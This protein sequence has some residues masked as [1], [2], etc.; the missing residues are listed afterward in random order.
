MPS[1]RLPAGL[2]LAAALL[3]GAPASTQDT[4]AACAVMPAGV[5]APAPT[6]LAG[7]MTSACVATYGTGLSGILV[8]VFSDASTVRDLM[9]RAAQQP[10]MR[11]MAGLGERA[12]QYIPLR[13]GPER[14]GTLLGTASISFSR[15]CF[16][17]QASFSDGSEGEARRLLSE[18]D[19]LIQRQPSCGGAEPPAPPPGGG[20]SLG[21]ACDPT[22]LNEGGRA[23]CNAAV[24]N[25]PAGAEI[26]YRWTVDGAARS[27]SGP[28]IELDGLAAGSHTVTVAARDVRSGVE[29]APQSATLVRGAPGAP[30]LG[31]GTT[32]GSGPGTTARPPFGSLPVPLVAGGAIAIAIA[33]GGLIA[34]TRGRPGARPRSPAPQPAA[35]RPPPVAGPETPT[36]RPRPGL[37]PE[38]LQPRTRPAAGPEAL[39]PRG[40]EAHRRQRPPPRLWANLILRPSVLAARMRNASATEIIGD[41]V[42]FLFAGFVVEV[43]PPGEWEVDPATPVEAKWTVHNG[44]AQF[45]DQFT[46]LGS[47]IGELGQ[48]DPLAQRTD[49]HNV[50]VRCAW[51]DADE[52][53]RI[54]VHL[55]V[56]VR[57]VDGAER[58]PAPLEYTTPDAPIPIVGARPATWI[59]LNTARRLRLGLPPEDSGVATAFADGMDEVYAEPGAELFGQP[60]A[61]GLGIAYPESIRPVE[62]EGGG[63]RLTVGHYFEVSADTPQMTVDGRQ[64]VDESLLA[65]KRQALVLRGRF[66][67]EDD[68]LRRLGERGCPVQFRFHP[69]GEAPG[70][71]LSAGDRFDPLLTAHYRACR[72]RYQTS[73]LPEPQPVHV[74]LKPSK[75][76][77]ERTPVLP[78]PGLPAPAGDDEGDPAFRTELHLRVRSAGDDPV[79]G[80]RIRPGRPSTEAERDVLTSI[81]DWRLLFKYDPPPNA[82][83]LRWE[84]AY[85]RRD[86]LQVEVLDVDE[87]G[88]LQFAGEEAGSRVSW[89]LYDH[90]N[91]FFNADERYL[92]GQCTLM[93]VSLLADGEQLKC[94]DFPIGPARKLYLYVDY[95]EVSFIG[96][97]SAGLIDSRGHEV[98]VGFYPFLTAE[99]TASYK[100]TQT[101]VGLAGAA[102]GSKAGS[103]LVGEAAL[104]LITAIPGIGQAGLALRL[105]RAARGAAIVAGTT[106]GLVGGAAVGSFGI[107]RLRDDGNYLVGQPP[108][109]FDVCRGWDLTAAEYE[110]V[111]ARMKEWKRRSDTN[112]LMYDTFG[113]EV[114]KGAPFTGNCAS[115][116][117][118]QFAAAGIDLKLPEGAVRRPGN[119]GSVVERD[120]RREVNPEP[121]RSDQYKL[122]WTYLD[123]EVVRPNGLLGVYEPQAPAPG[124]PAVPVVI[125]N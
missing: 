39:P 119:F 14:D 24:S 6:E 12:L 99:G 41:G 64:W 87:E 89:Y 45:V 49:A 3:A 32:P 46:G 33:I 70:A 57:S 40:D 18:T 94:V 109:R 21:L 90:W 108:H 8:Y 125:V 82:M 34:R 71:E 1:R 80:S 23:A 69:T 44:T 76:V 56:R 113:D 36:P 47:G 20:M 116:V 31:P 37:P 122:P 67:F 98:R 85:R 97:V 77:C 83:L 19:A 121:K 79:P 100:V 58:W 7:S 123:R 66:R 93:H 48:L 78:H 52:E 120:P 29:I 35:A 43:G 5:T 61:G 28:L 60:Y 68:L 111:L 13:E 62:P 54:S 63:P 53:L 107:G 103:W 91:A 65:R 50:A 2:L 4:G 26:A 95:Q 96:H 110:K 25:L 10:R 17:V 51:K 27:E 84:A 75:L 101:A 106:A 112:Q 124:A 86:D 72:D 104:L 9:D 38:L 114:F 92:L 74:K 11:E 118:D 30:P 55:R 73:G 59:A 117:L 22:G 42:D 81:A 102:V 115:F 15:G 88:R 16:F 105:I